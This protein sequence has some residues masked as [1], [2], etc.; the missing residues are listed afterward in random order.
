MFLLPLWYSVCST[1]LYLVC[2]RDLLLLWH[3]GQQ[4]MWQEFTVSWGLV[5]GLVFRPNGHGKL[6]IP[7]EFGS[8][9]EIF[10]QIIFLPVHLRLLCWLSQFFFS[11]KEPH[12]QTNATRRATWK[13]IAL[14]ERERARNSLKF[15]CGCK[16]QTPRCKRLKLKWEINFPTK[17]TFPLPSNANSYFLFS[18]FAVRDF[19]LFTLDF[20][21]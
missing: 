17:Q 6:L 16:H 15:R 21:R 13:K 19:T 9:G 11:A 2:T 18:N 12:D 5:N 8:S 7:L 20:N 4:K 10:R 14:V 1:T 3:P